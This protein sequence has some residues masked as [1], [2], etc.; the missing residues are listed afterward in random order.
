MYEKDHKFL[1]MDIETDD[2]NATHIWVICTEDMQTGEKF[3]FLNVNTISE[4]R[5]RF[6]AHV[7][8]YDRFV[9]HNGL[10]FDIKVINRLVQPDLI[11]PEQVCDTLIVSRLIDF[12][13]DGKGHSLKA[14]GKRLGDFKLDFS[15]WSMLT[16]EMI[17]YCHQDVTVTVKLFNRF[18]KVILDPMWQEALKVEHEIQALCERMSDNGF[19]FDEDKAEELLGEILTRM[20]ELNEGFQVD[21]PPKLTEVNRI[22]YRAKADGSLYSNVV[23]AQEKYFATA[24]DKSVEPNELVCYEFISFNPASPKQRIERLWE[25]GWEPVEKTAGHIK[26]DRENT[27]RTWKV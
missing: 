13:L 22:K 5:E 26:Y 8:G 14:W 12:T 9:L 4:E 25:A 19:Y 16:E 20:E 1:A 7:V 18:K 24:L 2:L 27:R 10:G 15:D 21:F 6:I 17:E 3:Q 11:R 23:K